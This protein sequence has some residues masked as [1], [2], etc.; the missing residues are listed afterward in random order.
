MVSA[1]GTVSRQDDRKSPQDCGRLPNGN[2][3]LCLVS[4][5]VETAPDKMVLWQFDD[6][7]HFKTINQ[8]QLLDVPGD[9]IKS[10][11]VR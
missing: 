5:T 2:V 10:E 7:A 3:L 11:I 1:K 6:L 8:S 9:V 4:G